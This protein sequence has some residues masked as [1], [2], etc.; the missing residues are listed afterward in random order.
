[1]RTVEEAYQYALKAEEKLV[2]KKSQQ[3]SGKIFNNGKGVTHDK[4]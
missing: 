1:M 3:S 2:I 4:A